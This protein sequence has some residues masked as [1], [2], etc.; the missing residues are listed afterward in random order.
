M[1]KNRLKYTHTYPSYHPNRCEVKSHCGLICIS[2][3]VSDFWAPFHEPVNHFYIFFGEM[4][5]Q[6]LLVRIWRK[7][8]GTAGG[9]CW[10][11]CKMVC[12]C[13]TP[14]AY[15]WS[16]FSRVWL[17]ALLWTRQAPLSMA[18]SRQ[19][20]WSGLPCPPLGNFLTQGSNPHLLH[21]PLC[22]QFFTAEPLGKPRKQNRVFFKK[23]NKTKQKG[24]LHRIQKICF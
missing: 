6:I 8:V 14:D 22:R 7:L 21:L 11:E 2:L 20:F 4:S 24:S 17:Y 23:Q 12:H 13:G 15:M 10:W 9:N 16:L 5:I 1:S 3:M 18:F 19:E